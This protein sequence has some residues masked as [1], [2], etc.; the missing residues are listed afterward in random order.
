MLCL[1]GGGRGREAGS[2]QGWVGPVLL[3]TGPFA[4][5]RR[6]GRLTCQAQEEARPASSLCRRFRPEG[7]SSP[8]PQG[9]GL[10]PVSAELCRCKTAHSEVKICWHV[11]PSSP[12][13]VLPVE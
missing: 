1:S 2:V 10:R 12:G 3:R 7:W 9:V 4:P 5:S 6:S 8:Q 11:S 13:R